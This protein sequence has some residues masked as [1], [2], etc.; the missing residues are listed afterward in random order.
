[1]QPDES[2]GAGRSGISRRIGALVVALSAVVLWAGVTEATFNA[3]FITQDIKSPWLI[4]ESSAPTNLHVS[5]VTGY[6]PN[7][8]WVGNVV[9]SALK[10]VDTSPQAYMFNWG[11]CDVE[12]ANT[13]AVAYC[14]ILLPG[15]NVPFIVLGPSD[16]T[17]TI[18]NLTADGVGQLPEFYVFGNAGNDTITD[19][20]PLPTHGGFA[21]Q[22]VFRG[23]PG[24]DVLRGGTANDVLNGGQEGDLTPGSIGLSNIDATIA[25]T[26]SDDFAANTCLVTPFRPLEDWWGPFSESDD[27][28]LGSG[29]DTLVGNGGNDLLFGSDGNDTLEGGPGNDTLYGGSGI[30]AASYTSAP[31]GV[32]VDL[33]FTGNQNTVGAGIDRLVDIE[34]LSGSPYND[35]LAGNDNA[36]T[37]VG[38][39][40]DDSLYGRGGN[41]VL[42]GLE[43][44]D[45][46]Y[47]G[48]GDDIIFDELWGVGGGR[49]LLDGG[50]GHDQLY[51]GSGADTIYARDPVPGGWVYWSDTV[52]C[53][54]NPAGEPD[55]VQFNTQGY[56][57]VVSNCEQI[58]P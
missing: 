37:L 13:Y 11:G 3:V 44:D 1:M 4:Q 17:L 45:R 25:A 39:A 40:G 53:G 12:N 21:S 23:G 32:V 52:D 10:I 14:P 22:M 34:N 9:Y 20:G 5:V 8:G 49:D 43:G 33:T 35:I 51:G 36:N 7:A 55:K 26:C 15:L 24:N 27:H 30:D 56:A 6:F 54:D 46:M 38:Y 48:D 29:N 16:D 58:L 47:G 2:C 19:N 50:N 18:D 42:L 41:D 57:D 28:T 31:S